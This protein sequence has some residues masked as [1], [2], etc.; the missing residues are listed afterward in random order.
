MPL[1]IRNVHIAEPYQ[2]KDDVEKSL[3]FRAKVNQ[4][5]I[6]NMSLSLMRIVEEIEEAM[7]FGINE[8]WVEQ[9]I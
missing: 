8:V 6:N 4:I 1:G 3:L 2:A 7:P 5:T 9:G